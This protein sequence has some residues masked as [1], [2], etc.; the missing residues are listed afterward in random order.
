MERIVTRLIEHHMLKEED[1]ELYLYGFRQLSVIAC[2][3][4]AYLAIAFFYQKVGLLI[5][6]LAAFIP[7]R[8]YAG[9]YHATSQASCF[10]V[11]AATVFGIIT[12]MKFE[13]ISPIGYMV[14]AGFSYF[15]I[16]WL[17]PRESKNKPYEEGD[18]AFFRKRTL[19]L[20]HV[21]TGIA[22][23]FAWLGL[24]AFAEALCLGWTLVAVL[25]LLDWAEVKTKD[26]TTQ[27][28]S[29]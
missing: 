15:S 19:W 2:H 9:G 21:E 27:S 7:L 24:A 4:A 6:F 16:V 10:L 25:L 23:V 12:L 1:Y 3:L 28:N 26:R 5:V 8:S 17:A 22:I 13:V 20:L 29:E 18:K 14:M 11:S